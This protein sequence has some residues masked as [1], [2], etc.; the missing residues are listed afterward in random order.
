M[1]IERNDFLEELSDELARKLKVEQKDVL[2]V[3]RWVFFKWKK[4]EDKFAESI[5]HGRNS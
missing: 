4:Q 5:R 1:E 3:L 2:S